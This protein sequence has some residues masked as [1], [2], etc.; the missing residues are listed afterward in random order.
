MT[1]IEGNVGE[2]RPKYIHTAVR[3]IWDKP[4]NLNNVES[5]ANVPIIINKGSSW[6][7]SIGTEGSKGTKIFS[8]VGKVKNTGLVEVPMGMTLKEIIFNIGGGQR[9]GKKIKECDLIEHRLVVEDTVKGYSRESHFEYTS[10][11]AVIMGLGTTLWEETILNQGRVVNADFTDYKIA[12]AL[13]VLNIHPI[14][15]EEM[16]PED[17][18][19]PRDFRSAPW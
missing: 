13:N 7:T 6:Y 15:I 8:L 9:D 17:P 10:E 2:P 16:H 3:G 18:M 4:S 1:A 19:E 14:L 5:W 12:T 11:G